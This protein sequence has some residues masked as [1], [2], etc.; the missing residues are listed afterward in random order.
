MGKIQGINHIAFA[1]KD[2][3]ESIKSTAEI[4]GGEL[5]VKFESTGQKYIG[6]CIQLGENI[7]S[8]LQATDESSFVARH[9][10]ARGV[11][12]QH[13]GLTIE[14]LDAYVEELE[15]KGVRVDKTDM[16]NDK[17]K[18]ALV[19]PKTGNGIVLQLMEWRDGPMDVSPEGKERLK[20]KYRETPGL[21]LMME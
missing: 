7:I 9:I 19:G 15:R 6:A 16:A 11:G 17:F 8:F 12:V 4:L 10:E 13:M 21:R 18:E 5:I 20:Q 2:L 3:D 1:V 14:N